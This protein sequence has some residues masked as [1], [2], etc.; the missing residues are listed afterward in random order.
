MLKN[1]VNCEL[2]LKDGISF[3]Y[4]VLKNGYDS[5]VYILL[6]IGIDINMCVGEGIIFLYIVCWNG[7]VSIV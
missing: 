5:I 1:G 3:F 7:Y 2:C 4:I 6:K